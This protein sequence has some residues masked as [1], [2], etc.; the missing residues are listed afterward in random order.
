MND[1]I[2]LKSLI[3]ILVIVIIIMRIR[4]HFLRKSAQEIREEFARK[5]HTETNTLITIS[6]R[7]KQMRKLA[8]DINQELKLLRKQRH[9]YLQG[10]MELKQAVTNISHDLR[11]PLTAITGYLDLLKEEEKSLQAE[12]YLQIISERTEVMKSLTEELF[13]YSIILSDEDTIQTEEIYVNQ[14]LAE[15]ITG[16]YAALTERGITPEIHITEKKIIRKLN[17]ELLARI[18]SNL[19]NNAIKYSDGDLK[20]VLSDEGEICFS[21]TARK[22]GAVQAERLFDRFYTVETGRNATGLGLAIARNLTEQMGGTIQAEYQEYQL[23]IRL[24]F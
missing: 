18:F 10:D 15:S 7:D 24:L 14:V 13:R 21:N 8:D 22:L 20:I 9:Q 19:L 16:Y 1:I 6:T 4:I 2:L 3:V 11:T 5:L 12:T 23:I 17:K